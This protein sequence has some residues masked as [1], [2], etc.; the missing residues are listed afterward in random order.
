MDLGDLFEFDFP[1]REPGPRGKKVI[2]VLF[3]LGLASLSLIGVKKGFDSGYSPTSWPFNASVTFVFVSLALFG[4]L[5]V[6][7]GI[8]SHWPAWLVPISL[9]LVFVVRIVFGA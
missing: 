4:V 5:S 8:K 7:L 6:A 2:R 3:G 9:V 1:L